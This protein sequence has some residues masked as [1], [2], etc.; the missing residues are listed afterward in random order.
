MTL[1][2]FSISNSSST[3]RRKRL[4]SPYWRPL[5]PSE[6]LQTCPTSSVLDSKACLDP[7]HYQN[8]LHLRLPALQ[9]HSFRIPTHHQRYSPRVSS[10]QLQIRPQGRQYRCLALRPTLRLPLLLGLLQ[11][12]M[13]IHLGVCRHVLTVSNSFVFVIIMYVV[14][15]ADQT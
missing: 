2:I 7:N 9:I 12:L 14:L 15:L 8:L 3:M 5:L 13:G 11:R 1:A 10:V 6:A 4:A